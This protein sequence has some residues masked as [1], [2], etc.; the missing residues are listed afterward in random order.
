MG[1]LDYYLLSNCIGSSSMQDF[2][3]LATFHEKK[4]YLENTHPLT[5]INL[6]ST[7]FLGGIPL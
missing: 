5:V 2:Q 7:Y 4:M 1:P 6:E 3:L